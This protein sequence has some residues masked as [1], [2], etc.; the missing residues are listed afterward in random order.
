MNQV[1]AIIYWPGWITFGLGLFG[2]RIV[3]DYLKARLYWKTGDAKIHLHHFLAGFP[4]M[5]VS[6]ILYQNQILFYAGLITGFVFALFASE[7][8]ELILRHWQP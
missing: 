6:V 3:A 8:K 1:L 4:L 7:T 5:I 2:I